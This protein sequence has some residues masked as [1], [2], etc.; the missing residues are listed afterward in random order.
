MTECGEMGDGMGQLLL[1][2]TVLLRNTLVQCLPK[3][4]LTV[5]DTDKA[6]NC[7]VD[8]RFLS[9]SLYLSVCV[10]PNSGNINSS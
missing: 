10:W 9:L 6:R 5:T 2:L 8:H 3:F 1:L 7:P 4:T